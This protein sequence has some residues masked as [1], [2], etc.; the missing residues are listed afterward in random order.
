VEKLKMIDYCG[1][2]GLCS[3]SYKATPVA[4]LVKTIAISRKRL[5]PLCRRT[6]LPR[7]RSPRAL[8]AF[9]LIIVDSRYSL[10]ITSLMD[11]ALVLGHR[12]AR[13]SDVPLAHLTSCETH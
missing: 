8:R 5:R 9:R 12:S 11:C 10:V 1:L 3:A 6:A 13:V 4:T 7:P 2:S